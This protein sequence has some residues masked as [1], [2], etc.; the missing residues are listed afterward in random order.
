MKEES[1]VVSSPL[2]N[3]RLTAAEGCLTRVA[4]VEEPVSAPENELLSK[5]A[6]QL[7]EYFSGTRKDFELPLKM[8]GTIFQEA[9]W[10]CLL[11]IPYGS[12]WSY[13]DIAEK[14]NNPKAVRAI[15]Q[16]NKANALPIIVP[17]HRVIGKDKSLTGYAGKQIDKK[18]KLLLIE[19]Q[20]GKS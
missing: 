7:E 16:A 18:E 11:E 17:C 10:N 6:S 20:K 4:F 15:G 5:A 14:I 2:G 3:L 13:K 1:M 19:R 8:E 9:V 12:T